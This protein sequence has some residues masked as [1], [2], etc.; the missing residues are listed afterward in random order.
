[1]TLLPSFSRVCAGRGHR[2]AASPV[3]ATVVLLACGTA[4]LGPDGTGAPGDVRP[5]GDLPRPVAESVLA[6]VHVHVVPMDRET[7]LRDHVVV[8]RDGLIT[9]MGPAGSLE[10]PPDA[11]VVDGEGGYLMPGLVDMHVHLSR[12]DLETYVFHGVTTVRNMWGW[13]GV[14]EM[15]EAVAAGEVAGPTIHSVSPGLDGTP[16]KWPET[17]LVLDPAD[18]DSVVQAQHDAGWRTLKV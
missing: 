11:H 10:V 17:Q 8:V 12:N 13:S 4:A 14:A 16:P 5:N 18:A 1:M 15:R 6:F 9:A 7:V 2:A 3:V